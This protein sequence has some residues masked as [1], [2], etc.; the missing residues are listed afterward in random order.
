MNNQGNKEGQKENFKN[1]PEN[2]QDTK[3]C[4]LNNREFKV[5]VLKKKP[6]G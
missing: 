4:D 5:A 1:F 2:K 3:H 6:Q